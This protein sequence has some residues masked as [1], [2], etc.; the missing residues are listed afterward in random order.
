MNIAP[1]NCRM[2]I[3]TMVNLPDEYFLDCRP[4]TGRPQAGQRPWRPPAEQN[5][6]KW[7]DADISHYEDINLN[8]IVSTVVLF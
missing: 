1:I 4:G 5:Y 8:L 6:G 2:N 7:F 3:A